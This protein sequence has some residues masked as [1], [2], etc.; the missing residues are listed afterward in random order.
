LATS[1]TTGT[2]VFQ[3]YKLIDHALRRCRLPP[4]KITAEK[5]QTALELL[6]LRLMAMSNK[7]ITLFTLDRVI[8]PL[9][10]GVRDVPTPVG[11]T[12]VMDVNLRSVQRL[13]GTNSASEGDADYAFDSD[14][15]TI[16]EQAA[17]NGWIQTQLSSATKSTTFGLLPGTSG[18]WSYRIQGSDDGITFTDVYTAT[19]ELVVDGEWIWLDI[20]GLPPYEFWRLQAFGGTTLEVREL[21][22]SN[23]PNE[24]PLALVNRDDYDTLPNK[25][26]ESRPTEYWLDLQRVRPIL[27]LWPVP[28]ESYTFWQLVARIQKY[29]EDVGTLTQ[30]VAVPAK[31]YMGI[32]CQLSYD[33][34]IQ[35]ND[36]DVSIIPTLKIDADNEMGGLWDGQSDPAPTRLTPN[37]GGYTR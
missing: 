9:Y 4:Q 3:T 36:V 18:T 26:F 35:D 27:T 5:I 2:T 11:T 6:W 12:G 19:A 30:E 21:V 14:I 34:A 16:C 17:A 13:L 20:D 33:Y 29:I 8:L 24:I 32:L 22:F 31:S 37:I 10:M 28:Q 15:D 25:V 7:G 23:T 1:G